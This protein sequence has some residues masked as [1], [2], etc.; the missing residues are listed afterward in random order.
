M[1]N[2]LKY[3]NPMAWYFFALCSAISLEVTVAEADVSMP[4]S[5]RELVRQEGVISGLPLVESSKLTSMSM[6]VHPLRC[7]RWR[8]H[9]TDDPSRTPVGSGSL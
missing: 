7:S 4:L 6:E 1:G 3:W 5:S 2:A 8:L 9:S